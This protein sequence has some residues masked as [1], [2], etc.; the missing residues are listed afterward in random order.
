MGI[1]CVRVP[2]EN[3]FS[4]FSQL[5]EWNTKDSCLVLNSSAL[6]ACHEEHPFTDDLVHQLT[7]A[8]KFI[9]VHN[10]NPDPRCENIVRLLSASQLV[11]VRPAHFGSHYQVSRNNK[12]ICGPFSGLTFGF[13]NPHVDRILGVGPAARS[14]SPLISVDDSPLLATLRRGNAQIFF[15]AT[16]AVADIHAEIRDKQS[17]DPLFSQLMPAAMLLRYMFAGQC[18]QPHE[19]H[20]TLTIDDPPLWP[21][22]GYLNYERLLHSMD[23]HDFH[24]SIAFIPHNYRRDAPEVVQLFQTRPDRFSICFHGNDHTRAELGETDSSILNNLLNT[25]VARMERHRASTSIRCDKLM[26]FPQGVFSQQAMDA[27][28]SHNFLAAVNTESRPARSPIRIEL[29]ELL[30]PALLNYGFPLFIR[31]PVDQYAPESLAFNLF[32]GKPLFIGS[33]HDLFKNIEGLETL[34]DQI[35]S[36]STPVRWSNLQ[37]AINNSYLTRKLDDG[38]REIRTYAS[39]GS[40]ENQSAGALR[41]T[42]ELEDAGSA[43]AEKVLL[44]GECALD[45]VVDNTDRRIVMLIPPGKRCSFDAL[46]GTSDVTPHREGAARTI[47]AFCRRRLSEFRDNYLSKNPL[48]LLTAKSLQRHLQSSTQPQPDSR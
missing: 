25:A 14:F 3:V 26:V 43:Q 31:K 37:T 35:N 44:N 10:L 16:S 34:V 11:S 32:F 2:L 24:S 29:A 5:P 15:L 38:T 45:K 18:W 28:R 21:S 20:A 41:F 22:Y 30:Q 36:M 12:Q 8:F 9:L 4:G 6:K 33:H 48:V 39:V 13:A 19:R 46:D 17:T 27:L 40:I 1:D 23:T 7:S 42:I 47:K